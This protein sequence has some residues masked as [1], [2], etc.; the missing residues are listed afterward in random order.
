MEMVATGASAI[1]FLL[2]TWQVLGSIWNII[3]IVRGIFT[4]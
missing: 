3:S 2:I 4:D 1:L